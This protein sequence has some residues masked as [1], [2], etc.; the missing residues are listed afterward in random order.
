MGLLAVLSV[1]SSSAKEGMWIPALLKN[2]A[3]SDM[4]EMGMR[5]TAEDIYSFNK[6]SLKDAIVH[7]GGG[8]TGEMISEQ[9]LL[10]TNHH[11][12]YGQIQSHSSVENDLLTN[13]FWAKDK[14][15]EL[16]NPGLT[17]TFIIRM[18]DVTR[19]VLAGVERGM[20]EADRQKQIAANIEA[21]GNAAIVGTHY[22]F[23]I[24]P[25][26]FGN[27]YYMF[28]TETFND[29]RLVG[30]PPSSIGKFGFDTD[31]WV[32]PRHTGDFSMFRI[33][34]D[35]DN[36]P[37]QISNDNK[38]FVPRQ[39]LS[40]SMRGVKT[41]DFTMVYGFPGYTQEYLSSYAVEY[42]IQ[43]QN[44][45]RIA[46]RDISL[47]I[48]GRYMASSPAVR[49]Q[50]AA[51]QS[52]IANAWKKWMGQNQGLIRNDAIQK[53]KELETRFRANANMS[54][55]KYGDRYTSIL[56]KY[57][58]LYAEIEKYEFGRD[59][60]IE[61]YYMGPEILR[62]SDSYSVLNPLKQPDSLRLKSVEKLTKSLPGYFKNYH[63]AL[64]RDL[65]NQ[66]L[67]Y[68][69][70]AV[71]ADF[72]GETFALIRDKFDGN[73]AGYAEYVFKKSVFTSPEKIKAILDKGP[74]KA[75][76]T[77]AKDPAFRLSSEISE[78]YQQK[79]K[80]KYAQLSAQLDLLHRDYMEGLM[81][82]LPNEKKYYPD[83][84]STLRV[85]YGIVE[86]YEAAD[87]VVYHP[88][89]T[90]AGILEKRDT[91][92]EF[93]VPDKLAQLISDKDYGPYA[94][95]DGTLHVAFIASNH[96]TGGNSGSPALNADGH[97]VGLNFDRTW[98][99][100]MSDIYYDPVICRNIMVDIRYVLFVVDKFADAPHL[101][102]EMKL[103]R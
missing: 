48:M 51:K 36:K 35:K 53:K 97:L 18:E 26:F 45:H 2:L 15:K 5:I 38:P 99:S 86:G 91:T 22:G 34:A 58:S 81:T 59:M 17:A 11:C 69:Y 31:N 60:F 19:E 63:A 93:T 100:T 21:I 7:F 43:K 39:A 16:K 85:T 103:V 96:T 87:A 78:V 90:A 6:S 10:L 23:L 1:L 55:D 47:G 101:I 73:Y 54:V 3:E 28:I 9:G 84:N 20:P 92:L 74:D 76:K 13:G 67:A 24:R 29:V 64:D 50:Y 94:D 12:G 40:I 62:F 98:E 66:M 33:Y 82:L 14:S 88:H 57:K 27:Q 68:Y 49:I 80:D 30:A 61:L 46:M 42:V 79:I 56:E 75:F 95:A 44:P 52:R 25:F 37:A 71:D 89:T 41:G 72:K 8:C 83:A 65:L 32:W 77:I 102:G 70:E 4:R